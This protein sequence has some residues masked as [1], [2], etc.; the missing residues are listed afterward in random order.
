VRAFAT[1][2]LSLCG[3]CIMR[4]QL[5]TQHV[6]SARPLTNR[7]LNLRNALDVPCTDSMACTAFNM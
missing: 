7:E 2:E 6:L 5:T 3:R 1:E 4:T